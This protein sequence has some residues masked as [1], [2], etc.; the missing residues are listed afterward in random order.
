[1]E[2]EERIRKE[3]VKELEKTQAEDKL[4]EDQKEAG[5]DIA[6]ER[7]EKELVVKWKIK[8]D[9]TAEGFLD[10]LKAELKQ[11]FWS[12]KSRKGFEGFVKDADEYFDHYRKN[13]SGTD[14]GRSCAK[15][16]NLLGNFKD[17]FGTKGSR[18]AV[19]GLL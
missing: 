15:V 8:G 1:M 4:W 3:K 10:I 18:L 13:Y 14:Y 19:F 12:G 7:V 2:E 17:M 16:E 11:G 6:F 5:W 9:K